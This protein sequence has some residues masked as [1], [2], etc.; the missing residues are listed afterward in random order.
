MLLEIVARRQRAWRGFPNVHGLYSAIGAYHL[1]A[2]VDADSL[3]KI[4]SL[5][6]QMRGVAGVM[7]CEARLML[8]PAGAR[9]KFGCPRNM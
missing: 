5:H 7:R 8:T 9:S 1:L 6:S 3:A 2:E 4:E